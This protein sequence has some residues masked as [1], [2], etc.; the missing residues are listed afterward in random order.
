MKVWNSI[1]DLPIYFYWKVIETGDLTYLIQEK[2]SNLVDH[3]RGK[4]VEAW[5]Q[6]EVEMYDLQ[7]SDPKFKTHLE[8]EKRHYLKKIQA[9]LSNK[10]IDKIH[11]ENS[12]A[13]HEKKSGSK[14]D[15]EDSIC[16]LEEKIGQI[17][18]KKMSTK[19]YY[20]HLKRLTNGYTKAN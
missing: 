16:M 12:K 18:D 14:F 7:L 5:E 10:P 4:L 15:Y 11:F 20:T 1:E 6:I 13:I 9:A 17:D 19:R 2:G 3:V 8:D